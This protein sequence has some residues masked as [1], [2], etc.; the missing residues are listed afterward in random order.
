MQK[1]KSNALT[2]FICVSFAGILVSQIYGEIFNPFENY[3]KSKNIGGLSLLLKE[4]DDRFMTDGR[5]IKFIG[6][7]SKIIGNYI[8]YEWPMDKEM[9]PFQENWILYG[10]RIF[11]PLISRFLLKSSEI[12]LFG[13]VEVVGYERALRRG[14]GV[15]SQL[16]LAFADLLG[17]R[18][19]FDAHMAGLGG[20]VTVQIYN[21]EG[22]EVIF[23]PSFGTWT[24]G[25]VQ[26]PEEL[27][28]E[29]LNDIKNTK[30][31]YLTSFNNFVSPSK[32][33][34]PYSA[35]SFNKQCALLWFV[36]LSYYLKWL[37]PVLGL[38]IGF[39][40]LM[41]QIDKSSVEQQ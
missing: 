13:H 17:S 9:M 4:L 10:L 15:C 8:K 38:I 35:K 25:S 5:S 34:G 11:D 28:D 24:F 12:E 2:L 3:A 37:V 26:K 33:W 31:A 23:D 1:F 14:Y 20:H 36:Y 19:G 30:F 22:R 40:R 6:F 7:T 21:L 32:G 29:F 18:Y 39:R 41:P 27:S 16:A